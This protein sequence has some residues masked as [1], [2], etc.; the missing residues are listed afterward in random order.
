MLKR[1]NNKK[2][3]QKENKQLKSKKLN[4]NYYKLAPNIEN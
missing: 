1:W 2:E 3:K 4:E